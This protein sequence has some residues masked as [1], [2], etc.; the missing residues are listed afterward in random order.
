MMTIVRSMLVLI[1]LSSCAAFAFSSDAWGFARVF[2][3]AAIV[4]IVLYNVYRQIVV[5]FAEKLANDRISEYTKQGVEVTC[6]CSRAIKNLIPIQL[7]TD[8]SYKCLDCARNV[9]VN[10]EVKTFLETQPVDLDK[11]TAAFDA[12]YTEV[13]EKVEDGPQ[14]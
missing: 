1:T 13:T 2:T 12:V 5:L 11:S 9:T 4:Q 10:V 8:N 6:P 7:N 14:I 3:I